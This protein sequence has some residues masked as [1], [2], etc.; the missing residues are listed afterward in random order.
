[1]A[2]Y[3]SVEQG[4]CLSSIAHAFGFADYRTIYDH[5][6][7]AALKKRRPNPNIL[8]PGD[9]LYI[10]DKRDKEQ[11]RGTAQ[12][13][14]F[15]TPGPTVLLRLRVLDEEDRPHAGKR[16]VL[17]IDGRLYSGCTS[18]QGWI[19]QDVPVDAA[20]AELTV[21]PV[22]DD[23]DEICRCDL[24][25]GYLDPVEEMTG[26]QARLNNLGYWCGAVDGL[27]GPRTEA[28]L[29]RFQRD[30][31]LTVTGKAD[32]Q[33]GNRLRDW[34]DKLAEVPAKPEQPKQPEHAA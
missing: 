13:H 34:H 32:A 14:V 16:Y 20:T 18:K 5:A 17:K 8:F 6:Q 12:R 28:A 2:T 15:Q 21:W 9:R 22:E 29:K 30:A 19:E 3:H 11:P 24:V 31:G 1:M 23:H 33:T 4:E 26:V 10:P 27:M 7:N 25:L